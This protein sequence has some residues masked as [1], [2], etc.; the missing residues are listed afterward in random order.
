MHDAA[1]DTAIV[2]PLNPSYVRRQVWFDPIP[3]LVV[4]PK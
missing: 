2:R 4:Q 3:L 1:Y